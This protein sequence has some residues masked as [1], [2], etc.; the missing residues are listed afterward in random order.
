[1]FN[2]EIT[3][4]INGKQFKVNIPAKNQ[5]DALALV[6]AQYAGCEIR[7]VLNTGYIK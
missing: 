2:F 1:M 5:G 4:S 3:I 6:R 7:N